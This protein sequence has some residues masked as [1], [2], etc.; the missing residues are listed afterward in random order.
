MLKQFKSL[1]LIFIDPEKRAVVKNLDQL[2]HDDFIEYG[3]SGMVYTKKYL[4]EKATL[5]QSSNYSFDHFSIKELSSA[6]VLVTYQLSLDGQRSLRSSIWVH[7]I[8]NWQ[9]LFHQGTKVPS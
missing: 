9:L 4:L 1:E 7:N 5:N 6:S 3:S 8:C 2:L